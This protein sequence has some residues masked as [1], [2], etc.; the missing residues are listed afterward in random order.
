MWYDV[1]F[2]RWVV[3]LLPPLLRSRVLVVLLRVLILPLI[4]LHSRF[5]IYRQAV[6]GR[7][8]VTA[9]VQD[10][11]RVLNAAFFLKMRQIYIKDENSE[12]RTCLC[13]QQEH[14]PAVFVNPAITIYQPD[15]VADRPNFTVYI[16]DFLCTSLNKDEDRYKGN[17]LRIIVNLLNYYKPAGRRYGLKIYDYE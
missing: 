6:E 4:Q 2:N 15:E 10:I 16:P 8:N 12:Q 7:L 1:D 11:E 13:F 9:S 3:Q 5:I 17:Y 14:M